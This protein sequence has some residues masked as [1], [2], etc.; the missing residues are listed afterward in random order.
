[1][2]A[3]T[4]ILIFAVLL[5]LFGMLLTVGDILSDES[6]SSGNVTRTE[7]GLPDYVSRFEDPQ[8]GVVC[9][10]FDRYE[11]GGISCLPKSQTTLP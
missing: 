6:S 3:R 5:I 9:W 4:G 8:A 11:K 2:N 10:V 7:V 1:M